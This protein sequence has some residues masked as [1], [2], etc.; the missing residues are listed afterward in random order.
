MPRAGVSGDPCLA[1][2]RRR[3]LPV[4]GQYDH[5]SGT[6][7]VPAK[8]GDY[9]DAIRNRKARLHL[10]IFEAGLGGV[11]PFG[12]KRLRRKGRA[13]KASGADP[14]DY[15]ISPTA[16]SFVP[17]YAQRLST[18]S[19]MYVQ[20]AR[21]PAVTQEQGRQPSLG[22]GRQRRAV[23]G[24]VT[25]GVVETSGLSMSTAGRVRRGGRGSGTRVAAA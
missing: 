6:G 4:L 5:S 8:D 24:R 1:R 9:H 7:Y 18:A 11:L 12:A 17:Y 15:T 14:T 25:V 10:V 21:H 22:G 2:R 19:V 23:S 20:R 3:G 13:A 16:R